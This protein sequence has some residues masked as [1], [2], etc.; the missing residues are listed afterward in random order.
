MNF[1]LN[2]LLLL[3]ISFVAFSCNSNKKKVSADNNKDYS[4]FN[5]VGT[6]DTMQD[7]EVLPGNV[8][9]ID[10]Y[11]MTAN[12]GLRSDMK[13][14]N[15]GGQK[16][17]ITMSGKMNLLIKTSVGTKGT[18]SST[19][20]FYF[21][22]GSMIYA[23]SKEFVN[24]VMTV[25]KYYFEGAKIITALKGA[26]SEGK[27][28]SRG[29]LKFEKIDVPTG[30]EAELVGIETKARQDFTNLIP[31]KAKVVKKGE[32]FVATTCYDGM[33]YAIEDKNFNIGKA[34][35]DHPVAEGKFIIVEIT[36]TKDAAKK[37][38]NVTSVNYL[39]NEE[40]G[41]DCF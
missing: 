5:R 8:K 25:Y 34:F 36:G 35:K 22:D 7:S 26:M 38:M 29:S 15:I 3:F 27:D 9:S 1:K 23:E 24:D 21:K 37:T 40:G 39:Y 16:G 12:K 20:D 31:Y 4:N 28:G 33:E 41:F 32:A 17:Q 19:K 13:D 11:V 14:V 6:L 18:N 30:K 10:A 2:F